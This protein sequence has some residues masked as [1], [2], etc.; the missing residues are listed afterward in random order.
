MRLIIGIIF[1]LIPGC[2]WFSEPEIQTITK[3]VTPDISHPELP[4]PVILEDPYFYVVS[5]ANFDEFQKRIQKE[6]NGVF[7]ALTPGDY[8]LLATNIQ[9]LRRYILE[10]K[11]IVVYYREILGAEKENS[12]N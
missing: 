6:N 9:E 8:E 12:T 11:Q 10:S 2:S 1:L 4:R 7:I 5:P 3:I